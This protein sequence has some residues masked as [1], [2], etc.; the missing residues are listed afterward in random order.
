[1]YRRPLTEI[2]MLGVGEDVGVIRES[3]ANLREAIDADGILTNKIQ[4]IKLLTV[5]NGLCGCSA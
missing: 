4:K 1:M 2:A 3:A 5:P